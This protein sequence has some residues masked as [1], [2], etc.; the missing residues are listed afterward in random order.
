MHVELPLANSPNVSARQDL[1]EKLLRESDGLL[2]YRKAAPERWFREA[3]QDVVFAER[4]YQRAPLVS[5]GFL[6]NDESALKGFPGIFQQ[7]PEFTLKDIELFL[8]PL[9]ERGAH[10]AV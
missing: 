2:L 3:F 4:L 1:H 8:A 5:K 9:R 10:A 7:S 6:L